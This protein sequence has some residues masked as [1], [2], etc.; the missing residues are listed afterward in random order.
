V[1]QLTVG[2]DFGKT[3]LRAGLVDRDGN[4][5]DYSETSSTAFQNTADVLDAIVGL[6]EPLVSSR[7]SNVVGVGVGSTG[8]VDVDSGTIRTSGSLPFLRN[9]AL[10][11]ELRDRFNLPVFVV[12]DIAAASLGEARFGPHKPTARIAFA[13]FGTGVGMALVRAGELDTGAHGTLGLISGIRLNDDGRTINELCSGKGLTKSIEQALGRT[14]DLAAELDTIIAMGN[15][16][17]QELYEAAVSTAAILISL[18][19]AMCDPDTIVVGGGLWF[20]SERFRS[21]TTAAI[22]STMGDSATG[23]NVPKV[24]DAAFREAAGV[25]GASDLPRRKWS[26]GHD[27]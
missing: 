26:Q 11:D 6:V 12:N 27:G 9:F 16:R 7:T 4:A 19:A 10:A 17:T 24:V 5:L 2:I 8:A 21:D 22:A 15:K 14:V 1:N 3:R 25:V 18:V 20:G 23:A 13:S